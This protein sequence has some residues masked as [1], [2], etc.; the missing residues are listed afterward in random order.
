WGPWA[1]GGMAADEALARRMRAGGVPPM[2]SSDAIEGLQQALDTDDTLVAIA[3]VDWKRFAPGFA[4]VR[5]TS[6]LAELPEACEAVRRS[7]EP[8]GDTRAVPSSASSLAHRLSGLPEPEQ[9]RALLDLVR[10]TVAAVLGHAG[11]ETVGANRAFKELGFDSLTAVELRNR[12]GA[13]AE[14]RLPATLIYDYPTPTALAD[15]LFTEILGTSRA[16]ATDLAPRAAAMVEDDPIAIVAMS[17]R[18]PGGVESPEDLWDLLASGRDAISEFPTD[19]GWDIDSLCDPRSDCGSTSYAREGGFLYDA[20]EFDPAFFGISPREALAMDPQ[21]R[22]LLETSWEAFERAGIDPETLRGSQAGVFIGTNGQDYLSLVLNSPEA[23]DGFMST[24]NSASVVSGRLAYTFGVE[25]P[26]MTVDTAC[27]SSLVALHLAAQALRSG[28]CDLALAGGVTVMSTPGAFVEFSRQRGLAADGRVKAFAA[29]ADGTGWGEGVGML[30]VERLSDARR[31]GHPVL[32]VV[33]GSAINQDGASNGLTAP[34]GPSQQRVIR[35]ALASAG[36]SA[37]DVDAVEAHGTG[38]TLGDPIEAQALLATYGQGRAEDRPLWLGSIKS[39]IGHTQAAAGVAGVIKMVMAIRHGVLPQTLHVDEPSPHVDWSAGAVELLTENREWPETGRPR[40]AG[41]SSFGVSGTN[42]HTV[43]EQAPPIEQQE[44][45]ET[46]QAPVPPSASTLWVLSA[47]SEAAL[48]AQAERVRARVISGGEELRPVDVAYSLATSRAALDVRAAVVGDGG[49]SAREVLLAGL[50]ALAAGEPGAQVVRGVA[51]EGRTALLFTGQGSQRFGMGREL[52]EAYPVFA[53][54]LDEVFARFEL[55]VR[56]AV[57]GGGEDVSGLLDQTAYTQPALFAIEVALFRLLESWG[58]RPDFLSGHSIGELAA[59][60][61]AGV[62]SLDDACALVAARGRLMQ[63]LPGGGA[64]V[65]VQAAEE[66]VI[67]YLTDADA[68]SVAAVNG[69]TSVVIAGDESAVLDIAA[70]FEDQGRKSRRLTVS[71]AFHSP[72][73]DGML[74]DFRKVA[75]G[76]SYEAPRIPVVSNLTGTIAA[77]EEITSPDFW[78]RH[79]REAVRFHDGIRTL[80]AENVTTFIELGPD[81]VLSALAQESVTDTDALAFLPLLR[82]DRPEPETLT[83]ALAHAHTRGVAIDW[84]AYYAGT[85]AH[86]VDLPTYPFQRRRYWVDTFSGFGDVTSVGIGEADHPLL[87]AAVELPESDGCLFTGRLSLQ[88]HPWLADHTVMDQA[89]LPETAFVELAFHAGDQVGCPVLAELDVHAPLVLPNRGGVQLRVTVSES[90]GGGDGAT[91][92]SVRRRTV[93]VYSRTMDDDG[94]RPDAPWTRNATAILAATRTAAEPVIDVADMANMADMA[95]VWPP[96]GA[97]AVPVEALYEA[98]AAAGLAHGD[99]FRALERAW[100][101]E[102]VVFAE[103]RL[104]PEQREGAHR[105]ALHPALLDAALV[106]AHRSGSGGNRPTPGSVPLAWREVALHALDA[107]TL[108]VRIAPTG[109]ASVELTAIDPTGTPV[110][111]AKSVELRSYTADQLAAASPADAH[112]GHRDALFR[113]EWVRTSVRTSDVSAGASGHGGYAVV[114]GLPAG[115]PTTTL[116]ESLTTAGVRAES[117]DDLASLEKAVAAGRPAPDVIVLPCVSDA[118]DTPAPTGDDMPAHVRRAVIRVLGAVQSWLDSDRFAATRLVVL[119]RGA[120]ATGA[121]E[122]AGD[123]VHAAVWGLVRSAQSE[124]PDR[125]VLVDTDRTD[126]S[127]GA[128]AA[129][130]ASGEPELALRSGS[131]FAPRLARSESA[132]TGATGPAVPAA[133]AVPAVPSASSEASRASDSPVIPEVPVIPDVPVIPGINSEGTVLIT[134]AT[135]GLGRLLAR[136]LAAEHG[137]RHLLL[138][139]RSGTSAEGI[140]ELCH[141]LRQ[142]GTEVTVAA[143][144]VADRAALAELLD[145]VPEERPL[146]AVVH[147]AAVLDDGVV[148][149]MTPERVERVM[150]PKVDAAWNL[151]ELTRNMDLSAFVLFSAAA[152]TLGAAGQANYAAANVFLDALARHRRAHALPALS[153]V[154]G[155]WAEERGMAGRLAAADRSRAALGGVLPLSADQGLALFD[156]ACRTNAESSE[157][158]LVPLRLDFG[159]LR[160]AA[161][162]GDILPVFRGLVRTPVR[163]RAAD[164]VTAGE[165]AAEG[166]AQRL[167]RLSAAEREQAVLDLVRGQVAAVLGHA[168]HELVGPEQAF[169]ELGFDSLTA[170]ELRNQLGTA[171]DLRLPATLIYDYPTP[172]AL[173]QHLRTQVAPDAEEPEAAA[174]LEELNRLENAFSALA[175][176]DLFALTEDEAAHARVAV[177]LQSLLTQWNEARHGDGGAGETTAVLE[178]ASDDELFD[179]IDKRFG[180]S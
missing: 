52:Y 23:T 141:E 159:T 21:Q 80:E 81:G 172:A 109:D 134:G 37:A 160:A 158:V 28:E 105:F 119:T 76:L 54:A 87:G 177:R 20:A 78:V 88:S 139:S 120:V 8:A 165:G 62:L 147:T 74:A 146:T 17:C 145:A 42:A 148:E 128:L 125:I 9:R 130:V 118:D 173:A 3:D 79:V 18:F 95:E 171:T 89:V 1:E 163:R 116:T 169:R 55:P 44:S 7:T 179:F 33:R 2:A 107:T 124:N 53:R 40:R 57:F 123:L 91:E 12:L 64:M 19:R 24:G 30:L 153:L 127:Y 149:L 100:V 151:H 155:M 97:E 104:A 156:A 60:H 49:D 69:P 6:L 63:E 168:S 75:E 13:A 178:D 142:L 84:E 102:G 34:N 5:P 68:V 43:L 96:A 140:T 11:L 166:L 10:E 143:C 71:H 126:A 46:A 114:G 132:P 50:S 45:V 66:E 47:K 36:L 35:Q 115:E 94:A 167:A 117:F 98:S 176:D 93:T 61:C 26:T 85:G 174:V 111:S 72:H 154:W 73:M 180:A 92:E 86:R 144:D 15:H 83:T 67:A 25:G 175:P 152:G 29:G 162:S 135:G 4:A 58:V 32:A 129:A 106:T 161:A 99:A 131:A 70:T 108:R 41:V 170:V 22:L 150:R 14:L 59:A 157:A 113:L 112:Y 31:K 164:G 82:K 110:L 16:A 90:G 133:S 27:S 39:N 137:A 138:V 77:A 48:R 56:E 51:G 121:D 103:V 136:H 122:D 38:T 101:R 65:A